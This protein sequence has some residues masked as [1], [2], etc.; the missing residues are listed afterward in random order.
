MA[1]CPILGFLMGFIFGPISYLTGESFKAIQFNIATVNSLSI[2]AF[3]SDAN[4]IDDVIN[5]VKKEINNNNQIFWVCPL[6]EDSKK[7]DH[8]SVMA[9]YEHLKKI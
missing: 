8:Q 3:S 2:L 1:T 9:R 7:I 5:F 4:K 6:I